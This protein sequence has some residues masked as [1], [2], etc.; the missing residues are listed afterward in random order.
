M[1]QADLAAMSGLSE[2]TI[3]RIETGRAEPRLHTIR[4][5]AEA[6]DVDAAELIGKD[7]RV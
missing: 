3:N 4:K 2:M 6:L 5:L 1:T 7:S